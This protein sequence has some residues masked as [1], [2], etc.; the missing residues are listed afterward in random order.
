LDQLDRSIE[1]WPRA[2]SSTPSKLRRRQGASSNLKES[3]SAEDIQTFCAN[4]VPHLS[5]CRPELEQLS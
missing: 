5:F 4:H 3:A 1:H 2:R